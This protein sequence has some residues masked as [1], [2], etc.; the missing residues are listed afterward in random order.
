M[1]AMLAAGQEQAP[2]TGGPIIVGI[3]D[4]PGGLAALRQAVEIARATGAPLVAVRAWALGLPRHGG[5]RRG[6]TGRGQVVFAFR[7]EEPRVA[8]ARLTRRAF[9]DAVNGI[10][11]D[12]GV[13]IETPEGSPGPV[14]TQIASARGGVLVVGTTPGHLLKRI[15]HGSVS[16]YCARHL[17]GQVRVVPAS[18]PARPPEPPPAGYQAGGPGHEAGW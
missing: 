10:P 3:D 11:P 7:G 5:L 13:T 2:G 8:A 6:G 17:P 1:T 18:S 4:S 12:L 15:L 16:A 9:R 14:L